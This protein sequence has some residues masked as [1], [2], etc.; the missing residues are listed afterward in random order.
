MKWLEKKSIPFED[1]WKKAVDFHGHEG[2]YLVAGLR[3]GVYILQ[4]LS[5]RGYSDLKLIVE[6]PPFTPYTCVLDGLQVSTGCTFGKGNIVLV[7]SIS[8]DIR[9]LAICGGKRVFL[10]L[11]SDI[12]EKFRE[13]T[14]ETSVEE[15]AQRAMELGEGIFSLEAC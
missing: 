12:Q 11:P 6:S 3:M 5:S 10:T 7:P 9:V 15:A 4:A 1:L 14:D 2:P 8:K 13:W